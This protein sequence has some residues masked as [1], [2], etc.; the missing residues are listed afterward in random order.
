MNSVVY[1]VAA[2]KFV[3][4]QTVAPFMAFRVTSLQKLIAPTKLSYTLNVML[5]Y[6]L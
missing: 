5:T 6:M 3:P 2:K 4:I 1:H